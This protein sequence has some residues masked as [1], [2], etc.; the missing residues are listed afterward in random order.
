MDFFLKMF[1]NLKNIWYNKGGRY[2][3][4]LDKK[5]K[6]QL[7][8]LY[9]EDGLKKI[10]KALSFASEKHKGNKRASGEDYIIHPYAVAKILTDLKADQTTVICGFLHDCLDDTDATEKEIRDIFGETV[11]KILVGVTKINDI[12]RAYYLHG[13]QIE[14]LRSIFLAMGS[15]T[16]VALVKLADRLHNIQTLEYLS[17]PKQIKIAK[18]TLDIYVPIAE[19]LGMSVFKRQMEDL[20]FKYVYPKEYVEINKFLDDYF[21]KSESLVQEIASEIKTL[22]KTHNIDAV[23][24][25]RRKSAFSIFNKIQKKGWKNLFDIVAHRIIVK[26]VQDCYTMLGAV[27]DKWKPMAGRIKDYISH[28]KPN[29]YMSLHTTVQCENEGKD[30][31]FEVQIRTEEMHN[32]CEYGIAAHWIYK[33]KGVKAINN[34]GGILALKN[35]LTKDSEEL[36]IKEKSEQMLD[37]IQKEYYKDKIFVFTPDMSIIELPKDSIPLDFAYNIHSSLGNRCVGAKVNGKMVTLVTPLYT[38]DQVEIITNV[39]SKGPSRDW[40][41]IVKSKEALSKIKAY[42]KKEKKEENIKLGKEMLE[43]YAKRQGTTLAKLF[44]EKEVLQEVMQKYN[45]STH[46]ELCA[47]VGY[48]GLTCAQ[49]LGK[50]LLKIKEQKKH[51]SET[52]VKSSKSNDSVMIGGHSDL[53]K[54]FAKCCNPIPGDDIVGYVSR[55]KGVTVHRSDC[56]ALSSLENDRIINTEWANDSGND[57]YDVS[58]KVYAKNTVG[59]LASITNK[60]AENKLDITY[61]STDRNNRR[62]DVIINVGLKIK[63]RKQLIEILNK[64]KALS[65]VYDVYR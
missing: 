13:E 35:S 36:T 46:E 39:N 52:V 55:G 23:V 21:K 1:I 60:I 12:K 54:K 4:Q 22:A 57:L 19:R 11:L 58:F 7:F 45:L 31:P 2:I 51:K 17:E 43:E 15:D 20:C 26:N 53:L 63:S 32:F 65:H 30:V 8:E 33:E 6:N 62:E 56:S 27:N 5:F 41:K 44:E 9:G 28:P 25:S 61:V 18:E 50:F 64:I 24:Q 3:M 47:I 14:K 38:G 37:E 49:I 16:R 40:M 59:V 42:F 10:E 34:K 29:L 48:G